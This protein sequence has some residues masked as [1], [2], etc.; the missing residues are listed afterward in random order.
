MWCTK[1]RGGFQLYWGTH[2]KENLRPIA[3]VL[4]KD[5]IHLLNSRQTEE[6]RLSPHGW[7]K[8]PLEQF[9]L[10]IFLTQCSHRSVDI[11]PWF[12]SNFKINFLTTTVV[13]FVWQLVNALKKKIAEFIIKMYSWTSHMH[14]LSL[15]LLLSYFFFLALSFFS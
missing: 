1:E 9:T 14:P 8:A 3:N 6:L 2:W 11:A 10:C 15:Y 4:P 12:S 13:R 5:R 7:I